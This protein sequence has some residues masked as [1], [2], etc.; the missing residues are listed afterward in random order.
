M[1]TPR[2]RAVLLLAPLL[3]VGVL[4]T[5]A[6]AKKSPVPAC[7]AR[8][9]LAESADPE[10]GITPTSTLQ[11]ITIDATGAT[12]STDC[13]TVSTRPRRTRKGWKIHTRW[14]PC[15]GNRKVFLVATVDAA[16]GEL[17]GVLRSRKPSS[18]LQLDLAV[19]TCAQRAAFDSTFKGIQ[20]VI[21]EKHGCTQQACHGSTAKQGG[22]DL[23]PV[24]AYQ[25]LFQVR[26]TASPFN[27]VEPGDQRRS[28]LWLKLAAAT[29]PSQLPPGVQVAGAPMPNG[30]PPSKPIVIQPLDP[31]PAGEGVQFVM[32][33]WHLEAHSEHEIC[34]ATYYDISAQVPK[35][36]QDPTGT[37]FRF[38]GQELRQDPQSHHL[39]LNRYFGTAS[40]HDPAFGAWT[41]NGGARGGADLRAD[42]PHVMR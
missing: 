14:K 11:A 20:S 40:P 12:V 36:F 5:P 15:G 4:A 21:F 38:S 39:I 37:M 33:P 35:E 34:F 19:S 22:L 27:R 29:D 9:I 2:A 13:S 6:V 31:P 24:V 23:S 25:N 17:H 41:C 1:P 28:F 7:S 3:L 30:L 18:R 32:P 42:R 10:V 16:C 8:F 26:S